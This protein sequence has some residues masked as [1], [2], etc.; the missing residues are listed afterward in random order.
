MRWVSWNDAV[1]QSAP[2]CVV[3]VVAAAVL[4]P[5]SS[6]LRSRIEVQSEE[7]VPIIVVVSHGKD[8]VSK[9]V[10]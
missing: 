9:N 7:N 10:V 3:D 8:S 6:S 4:V 2:W 1:A 5:Y